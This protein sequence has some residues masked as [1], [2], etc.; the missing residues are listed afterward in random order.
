M[1]PPLMEALQMLKSQ[2]KKERLNFTASW[3]TEENEMVDDS[4]DDDDLLTNLL[5]GD[6]Q[7]SLDRIVKSIK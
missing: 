2:L 3:I 1:S 5:D 7:D 4:L 6:F